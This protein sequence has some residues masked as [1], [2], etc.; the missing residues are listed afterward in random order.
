ML[1]NTKLYLFV[2]VNLQV[3]RADLPFPVLE[4]RCSCQT[5]TRFSSPPSPEDKKTQIPGSEPELPAFLSRS[6]FFISKLDGKK[7]RAEIRETRWTREITTFLTKIPQHIVANQDDP[8][9]K[10]FVNVS[11]TFIGLTAAPGCSGRF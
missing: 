5:L 3:D 6:R 8:L 1:N 11:L 9:V 4:Q 7:K 2:P 10:L